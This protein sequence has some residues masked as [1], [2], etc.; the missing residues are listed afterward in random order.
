VISLDG[1]SG[2]GGLLRTALG[3]AAA[4][5][6]AFEVEGIRAERPEPGLKPQHRTAVETVAG[7]CDAAVEGTRLGATSLT[8][9]PGDVRGGRADAAMG[10]AG[11]LPLLFDAVLP[12]AVRLDGPLELHATG[13]TDVKWSPPIEY[14]RSVKL[15]LLARFGL[16]ADVE[17]ARTGYYPAGGG[18]ATLR[19]RPSS[20]RP[21]A[22]A[23]RGSLERVDVLSTAGE[24]LESAAVADRQA[25]RAAERLREAGVPVGVRRRAYE[26]TD[27]PGSSLLLR[28]V[29]DRTLL[30]VDE[31]GERGRSSE[32]VADRAVDRLLELHGAGATVDDHMADQLLPFL[33]LWGGRLRIPRVTDH[34]EANLAVLDAFG[35][36]VELDRGGTSDAD[37]GSGSDPESSAERASEAR[38]GPGPD[39]L[40][41]GSRHPALETGER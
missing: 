26:P 24:S 5:G 9:R 28:A 38:S 7:R 8:F 6:Q 13:G 35:C 27:S 12:L 2:G 36:A 10:T 22:L 4:T 20:G 41:T 31:L 1:R 37:A 21:L 39:A 25:T 32:T 33:G 29:Y 23:D 11:S 16:D 18:E 17:V 3:L 30:G 40:V 14:L 15:P 19:L 34:V